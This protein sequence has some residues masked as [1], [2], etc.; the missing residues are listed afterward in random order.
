[1]AVN[2]QERHDRIIRVI[3]EVPEKKLM[4]VELAQQVWSAEGPDWEAVQARQPELNLA[5]AEVRTYSQGTER[6][7]KALTELPAR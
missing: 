7:I 6:A 5:I 3:S 1:M 2:N 4:I